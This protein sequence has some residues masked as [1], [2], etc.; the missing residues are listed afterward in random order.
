MLQM[1]QTK[2]PNQNTKLVKS[3]SI[4]H[5]ITNPRGFTCSVIRAP[6]LCYQFS[7]GAAD[8]KVMDCLLYLGKTF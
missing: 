6:T 3:Y 1:L 5:S 8:S 7:G 4:Q 2:N